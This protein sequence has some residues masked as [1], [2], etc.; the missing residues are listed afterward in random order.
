MRSDRP[1]KIYSQNGSLVTP[2]QDAR[3]DPNIPF[4]QRLTC[5]IAEAC[6]ATGLG[7]TKLYDWSWKY[8]NDDGWT[9]EAG[10]RAVTPVL[11]GPK[12]V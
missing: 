12:Q 2:I 10:A 11:L 3:C 9:P 7:R 4:A 5:T 6:A 1:R 8:R